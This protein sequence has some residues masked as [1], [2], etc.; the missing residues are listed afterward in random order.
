MDDEGLGTIPCNLCKTLFWVYSDFFLR[1]EDGSFKPAPNPL[2]SDC[3][4]LYHLR[5]AKNDPSFV[6]EPFLVPEEWEIKSENSILR[7]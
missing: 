4:Q 6:V 3:I 5:Q 2:C 1:Q 7:W